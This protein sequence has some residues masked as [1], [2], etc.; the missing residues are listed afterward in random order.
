MDYDKYEIKQAN[1]ISGSNI[2]KARSTIRQFSREWSSYGKDERE[3][4]FEPIKRELRKY[5]PNPVRSG[6]DRV[7][8]LFPGVGLGRL[9]VEVAGEGYAAQG[10]EVTYQ[11]LLASNF[12]MNYV[13]HKESFD[14]YPFVHD[15]CNNL[16]MKDQLQKIRIPDVTAD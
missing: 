2:S 11:M 6:D 7:K 14:I 13:S 12:V 16:E 9:I 8:V 5:F 4:C 3:E 10:N 1:H 15:I